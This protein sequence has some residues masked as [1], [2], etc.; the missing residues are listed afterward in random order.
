MLECVINVSASAPDVIAE[1]TQTAD[2]LLLDVHRDV[3][4]HRSVLTLGGP[5][6]EVQDGARSVTRQAIGLIDL[7]KHEGVHP[8]LGVVDVVPFVPIDHLDGSDLRQALHHRHAFGEFVGVKLD[9]PCFSYGPERSLPEVRN[10]AFRT[11]WPD[12]GPRSP[13]P[14][15]GASCIGARGA[16]VAFNLV[17]KQNDI[18]LAKSTARTVRNDYLRTLGLQVG[19][20]VQ[21]SCNLVAPHLLGP[22]DA[23]DLVAALA[24]VASAELVGLIPSSVLHSIPRSRWEQLDCNEDATIEG[25]LSARNN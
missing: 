22:A 19:A 5:D 12:Y 16:L 17:L 14:R 2:S 10:A 6:D 13:D 23:Y 25:R 1:L 3:W 21:V 11:L 7:T 8:R 9:L 24:T 4:H 18:G 20:S 15:T